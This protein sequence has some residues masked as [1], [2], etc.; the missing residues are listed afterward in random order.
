MPWKT[1]ENGA[2]VAADNG[3]PIWVYESGP[4]KD[5]EAPVEFG[6]TLTTIA[7]LTK[8]SIERKNKLNELKATVSILEQEGIDDLPGYLEKAKTAIETVTNLSDKEILDA[9]Q[10]DKIKA[11]MTEGFTKQI[12][13]LKAAGQKAVDDAQAKL[14]AKNA[15]IKNLV[16]KGAFDG[17]E[18]LREKTVL[19]PDIAYSFFGS[20]FDVEDKDGKLSGFARDSQG[21]PLMSLARPGEI[22]S[23]AEA[24]ELL[25]MEHPQKDRLLKMDASGG[26]TGKPGAGTPGGNLQ[27]QYKEAKTRG[28][29]AGMIAAKGAMAEAGI[30]LPL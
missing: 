1:D 28:D 7:N 8:E 6:K 16:I 11:S 23:P 21:D 24:I 15:A 10:V 2:L 18:F 27:A 12:D 13:A 4:E 20:R 5:K 14:D 29:V 26:G 22:A 25:V 19:L 30:K 3:S 9:G 17:S